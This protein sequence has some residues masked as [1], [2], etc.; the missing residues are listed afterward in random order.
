MYKTLYLSPMIPSYNV[1]ATCRFFVDLFG[2][3]VLMDGE[4]T[5]VKKDAHLIHLLR[6]GEDIGEME[7][8]ME[9]DD[10]DG[11]WH[12]IRDRLPDIQVKPPF[13]REYGM[14]EF[15]LVI[16]H[17]KALMFVGQII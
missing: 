12:S 13:N 5:I 11:L 10:L 16:P 7:F 3:S 8:Y 9:V 2:F 6:A 15:H 14:R 17:T 4:Y 1:S